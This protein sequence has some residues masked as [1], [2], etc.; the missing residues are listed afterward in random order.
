MVTKLSPHRIARIITR[1]GVGGAE[2]Y[3]CSLT[4][5][6][7]RQHYESWLLCGRVGSDERQ[8]SELARESGVQPVYIDHLRREPGPADFRAIVSIRRLLRT[9]RPAIVETHTA[10]AGTLG[11]IG[12]LLAFGAAAETPRLIH[13][14]HG[15]VFQGYFN[16][17]VS[18]VL[19]AI[20]RQLARFTDIIVT[21]SE[22]VRRELIDQYRIS[23]ASKVRVVPL[24]FDFAWL[25][26]IAEYRGWLRARLAASERTVI[27]G[28]VG[29]FAKVKN[30]QLAVRAFAKMVKAKQIDARLVLIGDGELHEALK[31]LTRE[32][33]IEHLVM[34]C[35]WVL[36][37]AQ[38]YSDLDVTCLASINEGSPVCLIESLA[39]GIPV[40]ATNVGGVADTVQI[41]TDG[42]LVP[43]GDEEYFTAALCR[44]A[45]R[46][47]WVPSERR[48]VLRERHSIARMIADVK[49]IYEEVLCSEAP[50]AARRIATEGQSAV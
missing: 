11:R 38:I 16:G 18:T 46:S 21:V 20:E 19:I 15:H 27:V 2:R 49:T 31:A 42:E 10:K 48:R 23:S 8:W 45:Q 39:A 40:I 44:A 24:G 41:G 14:F 36:E 3:V 32:L 9:I 37:R 29:R 34:F 1:L 13:T 7:D 12:A 5:Q 33:E 17:P 30:T 4:E 47:S 25:K 43:S 50:P 28:V 26:K 6:L 35:G 22:T